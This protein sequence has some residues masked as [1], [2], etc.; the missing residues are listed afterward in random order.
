MGVELIDI[1]DFDKKVIE[2]KETAIVDFYADWC[3][4]C[5][6][7]GPVFKEV[8]EDYKGKVKFYKVDVDKNSEIAARFEVMSIPTTIFFKGGEK[9]DSFTGSK[10]KDKLKEF[11][12]K[13]AGE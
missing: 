7:F 3:M 4:P 6:I 1:K 12:D 8:S 11:I 10:P 9:A 5:K 2:E 13:N